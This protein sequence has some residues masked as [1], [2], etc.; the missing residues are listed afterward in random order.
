MKKILLCLAG[1]AL[2]IIAMS[3]QPVNWTF[4]AKKTADKTYEVQITAIIADPWS[5][6]SQTTPE[7]GPLPT[8]ITFI[9]NPLI[10]RSGNIKELGTMQS[11]HEEVF[12]VDVLYYKTKVTFVQTVKLK[13]SVMTNITGAVEFMACNN[14]QCLPPAKVPFTVKLN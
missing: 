1:M 11:K 4:A 9:N 5:I 6:Y 2:S 12:D 3:Q 8:Q 10:S 13:T 14:E 7:G